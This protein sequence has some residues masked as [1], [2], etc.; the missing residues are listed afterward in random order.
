MTDPRIKNKHDEEEH[1]QSSLLKTA[2]N[3]RQIKTE[4]DKRYLEYRVEGLS[5]TDVNLRQS[6][7][8]QEKHQDFN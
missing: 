7:E 1:G 5:E 6:I 2:I 3:G 4:Q 8:Q